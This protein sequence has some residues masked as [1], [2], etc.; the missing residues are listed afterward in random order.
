MASI[1]DKELFTSAVVLA[2][3]EI[4][5]ADPRPIRLT[6]PTVLEAFWRGGLVFLPERVQGTPLRLCSRW[7]MD[8]SGTR[9]AH[10]GGGGWKQEPFEG[11]IIQGFR[12]GP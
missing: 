4:T 12:Q 2:H 6:K 1:V 11:D 10:G 3:D 8:Q 9:R 7:T 5:R